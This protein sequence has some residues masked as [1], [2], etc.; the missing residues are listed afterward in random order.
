MKSYI[1]QELPLST[2]DFRRH[3]KAVGESN[4]EL[5][6]FDGLL[7]GLLQPELLL[8]PLINE[9]AVL[10][11]RIE[12]T[13]TTITDVLKYDAGNRKAIE[14]QNDV[15]EV[16]NY[17]NTMKFAGQQLA[18]RPLS[19]GLIREMHQMLMDGTRGA[20]KFPGMFRTKQNY[21][22]RSGATIEDATFVPPDPIRL[23]SDLES[24][25]RYITGNDVEVLLQCSLVHAQ[26]E[27]LHPFNDGNGRVGRLLIPLF[28]YQ[29]KKLSMPAF[30]I[31]GFLEKNREDYYQALRLISSQNDWD[32]W[33]EFFL[34]AVLQQAKTNGAI[35]KKILSLYEDM[36]NK[37]QKTTHSQYTIN[38]LDFLFSY[39]MFQSNN[40]LKGSGIVKKTAGHLLFQLKKAGIV[41]ESESGRGR[42]PATL[43]FKELQNI[44]ENTG[45][46]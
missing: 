43:I 34:R 12:G 11:S 46:N 23:Q 21:I 8:S 10:S 14:Q 33:I 22:G 19:L 4:A 37:V 25:E 39:P 20:E 31:S 36:K 9:E 16:I 41:Q 26:F 44:T 32:T 7:Q 35:V 45:S 13:Q 17:R 30:Y 29:K 40:F 38:V 18:E 24:L 28:L 5:A 15:Q 6:R 2:I 42:N 1:P 3:F 27:L